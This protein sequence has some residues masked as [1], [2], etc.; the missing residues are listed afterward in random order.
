MSATLEVG[1]DIVGQ[2]LEERCGHGELPTSQ[3]KLPRAL[4]RNWQAANLGDGNVATTD[5]QALARRQVIEV[6]AEVGLHVVD[7][8][9][10]HGRIVDHVL[11][12]VKS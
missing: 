1:D 2:R 7:V 9:P 4:A 3:A 8:D 6:L 10:K 12:Q 11:V 5:E